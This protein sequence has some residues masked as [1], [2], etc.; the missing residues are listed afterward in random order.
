[1][2]KIIIFSLLVPLLVSCGKEKVAPTIYGKWKL[3][4]SKTIEQAKYDFFLDRPVYDEG[5][6]I[7]EYFG[8]YN[9]IKDLPWGPDEDKIEITEDS[10]IWHY[11]YIDEQGEVS[12]SIRR[13]YPYILGEE[14]FSTPKYPSEYHGFIPNIYYKYTLEKNTLI[15]EKVKIPQQFAQHYF[16]GRYSRMK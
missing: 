5:A 8:D 7:Y 15:L 2:K 16:Y 13:S 1:M 14:Y 12:H 10:I 4:Y 6:I 11:I 9:E 3:E